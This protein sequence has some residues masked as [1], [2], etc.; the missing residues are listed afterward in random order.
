MDELV[1]IRRSTA[2][3]LSRHENGDKVEMRSM[4]PT[5]EVKTA[6]L[7]YTDEKAIE[8]QFLHRIQAR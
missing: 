5:H 4:M 7:N 6:E 3:V 1:S 2:P 8:A